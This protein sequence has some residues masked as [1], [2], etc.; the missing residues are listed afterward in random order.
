MLRPSY[1]VSAHQAI[2]DGMIKD[3]DP[4]KLPPFLQKI[5]ATGVFAL[6]GHG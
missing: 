3:I 5:K 1:Y 2:K 6:T 4:A